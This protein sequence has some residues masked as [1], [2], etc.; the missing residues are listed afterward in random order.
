MKTRQPADL[1]KVNTALLCTV[2]YGGVIGRTQRI[3]PR[4]DSSEMDLMII[5]ML[6]LRATKTSRI[7]YVYDAGLQECDRAEKLGQ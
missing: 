4:V 1:Q 7:M 6:A 2:P 5:T 3:I